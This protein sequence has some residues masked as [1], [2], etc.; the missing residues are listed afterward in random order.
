MSAGSGSVDQ[1][2]GKPLHPAIDGLV[3]DCDTALS[4]QLLDVTVGE[5]VAEVLA[6][7]Q[8]DHIRREPE[9]RKAGP[10][11]WYLDVVT[12]HRPTLPEPVI[13]QRNRPVRSSVWWR[14]R[15]RTRITA[16]RGSSRRLS[17]T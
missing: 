13:G 9:P 6:H 4:Q 16:E 5:A 8:Q 12:A 1:Q 7:R 15:D 14:F 11:R 3:I 2:R 17:P 10:Q